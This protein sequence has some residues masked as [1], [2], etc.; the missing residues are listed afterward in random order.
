MFIYPIYNHNW[1]NISTIYIHITR[2]ASNEIFSPSN[3]IHREV[4]R[5][6]DSS[7]PLYIFRILVSY[8]SIYTRLCLNIYSYLYEF[9]LIFSCRMSRYSRL[10]IFHLQIPFSIFQFLDKP[11]I[12]LASPSLEHK[13]YLSF[14]IHP[15]RRPRMPFNFHTLTSSHAVPQ[16]TYPYLPSFNLK[17]WHPPRVSITVYKEWYELVRITTM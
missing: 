15:S 10:T 16:T 14:Y 8:K 12:C 1:R 4:G 11:V 17:L 6:K 3:K 13:G 7:A 5:A 2:L 9:I